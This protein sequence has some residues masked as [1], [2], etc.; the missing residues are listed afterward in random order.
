MCKLP[1]DQRE[2][3]EAIWFNLEANAPPE[4]QRRRMAA[5][6]RALLERLEHDL[7]FAALVHTL[8]R[9]L[10]NDAR[11]VK[12]SR[13]AAALMRTAVAVDLLLTCSMRRENLVSLEL[14]RSI[15][16]VGKP[17]H[18]KWI[19]HL[20]P[21]DV[22]NGQELRYELEGETAELLE[23]YLTHWRPKLCEKPNSW[24]F[25][26]PDGEAINPKTMA[27]AVQSQSKRVLG[28]AITPHQFRHISAESFM[29]AYPDKLDQISE[30]LG[31]RD[32]NTTR[33]YYARSKQKQASRVFHSHVLKLRDEAAGHLTRRRRRGSTGR[34]EL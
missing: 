20:N 5:K 32:R 11:A 15:K 2:E 10:A 18:S 22:K 34:D 29:L 16:R 21:E 1:S 26:G 24:L 33:H 7:R 27:Y 9:R 4:R 6:N 23:E 17:P 28:V 19:I 13:Y 8:P 12:N 3:L 31:H 14:D 30:H 25:P